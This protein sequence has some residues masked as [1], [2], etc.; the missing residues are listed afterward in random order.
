MS[1][2]ISFAL[3]IR[4]IAVQCRIPVRNTDADIIAETKSSQPPSGANRNAQ[5]SIVHHIAETENEWESKEQ[6]TRNPSSQCEQP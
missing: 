6:E 5:N 2:W 1:K 4:V 3:D